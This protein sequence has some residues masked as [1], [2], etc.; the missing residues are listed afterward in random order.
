MDSLTLEFRGFVP[1]KVCTREKL[2]D[3]NVSTN[4]NIIVTDIKIDIENSLLAVYISMLVLL[5]L[6]IFCHS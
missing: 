2:I 1:S 5:F 3:D 4:N 6:T